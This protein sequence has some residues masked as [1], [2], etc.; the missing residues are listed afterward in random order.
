MQDHKDYTYIETSKALYKIHTTPQTWNDARRMCAREGASLFYPENSD[1]ADAVLSFWNRT[2]P[3]YERLFLGMSELMDR[4]IFETIDGK[5][6]LQ[7]LLRYFII[8]M[9]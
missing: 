1:E 5:S 6:A 3:T 2:Q 9:N 7:I 4:G 8:Y